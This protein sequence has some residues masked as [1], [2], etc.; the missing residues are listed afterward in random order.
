MRKST[1]GFYDLGSNTE[2]VVA[3]AKKQGYN[4]CFR[5][6]N[7]DNSWTFFQTTQGKAEKEAIELYMNERGN[8][9]K[10]TKD[11]A[12]SFFSEYVDVLPISDLI[13]S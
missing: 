6:I 8:K 11:E 9:M 2:E 4:F 3:N 12:K 7:S 13:E 10:V 1:L 5:W